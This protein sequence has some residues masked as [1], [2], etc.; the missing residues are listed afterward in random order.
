[1]AKKSTATQSATRTRTAAVSAR[2]TSPRNAG[3]RKPASRQVPRRRADA[4]LEEYAKALGLYEQALETLQRGKI[5]GAATLFQRIIDK[6]PDERELHERSHRY[7]E[8]CKRQSAPAAAP[9]TLEE[10][11]FAATIALNSGAYDEALS[12]L[13]TAVA[14]DPNSDHVQYMLAVA[15]AGAGET[16]AASTHLRRALELNPDNR[17]LARNEPSFDVLKGDAAF[18]GVLGA[19]PDADSA[20]G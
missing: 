13:E 10:R 5:K 7:L 16:A 4:A 14:E 15:R 3:S 20:G 18:Q 11:V 19:H 1:M 2:K 9:K 17:F 6:Y 12:H 8:V